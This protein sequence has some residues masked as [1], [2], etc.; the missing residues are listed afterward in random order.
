[1]PDSH[2]HDGTHTAYTSFETVGGRPMTDPEPDL[3]GQWPFDM[4][5]LLD[6]T[7]LEFSWFTSQSFID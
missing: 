4:N 6:S 3:F 2:K 7:S 5:E 1:M